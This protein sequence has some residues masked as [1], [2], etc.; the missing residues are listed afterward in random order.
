MVEKARGYIEGLPAGKRYFL[1]LHTYDVHCPYNPSADYRAKFTGN[2]ASPPID[3]TGLCGERDFEN[4]PLTPEQLSYLSDQYDGS[5]R[6]TDD[7]LGKLFSFLDARGAMK[8]SVIVVLAD[9]GEE[10]REHGSIGHIGGLHIEVLRVPLILV[11]S[12]IPAG[13]VDAGAG[14][15]DVMPTVLDLLQVQGPPTQGR[16]LVPFMKRGGTSPPDRP[17]FSE[18]GAGPDIRSVIDGDLHLIARSDGTKPSGE[19]VVELYDLAADP[20]EK[21]NL[22]AFRKPDVTR[23]LGLLDEHRA[24]MRRA[25]EVYA[26]DPTLDELE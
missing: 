14:L 3:T 5:I 7:G 23:L 6:E 17:L 10:F 18:H 4:L 16:S 13:K 11:A 15:V 8:D 1:F 22:Q 25:K 2:L 26:R 12:G 21:L 9:H 24:R 19:P 20:Q